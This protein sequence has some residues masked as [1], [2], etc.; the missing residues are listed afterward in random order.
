MAVPFSTDSEEV[1]HRELLAHPHTA[2]L[3]PE[4]WKDYFEVERCCP[5]DHWTSVYQG[6]CN[7]QFMKWTIY[8]FGCYMPFHSA[9]YVL[10]YIKIYLVCKEYMYM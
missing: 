9:T 10:G 5:L 8:L 6:W 7:E 1:I 2:N 3:Q 4:Q